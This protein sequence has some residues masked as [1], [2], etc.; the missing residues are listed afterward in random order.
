VVEKGSRKIICVHV[1]KGKKHDFRLFKESKLPI[2]SS[3]QIQ[4]DS[5]Y[6]GIQKK[7][8]N[9]KIPHKGKKKAPLTKAQK[10]ENRQLSSSRVVVENII[11][12]LK[13]FK[14]LAE[15]YRNRR[16]KFGLRL[17]LIAAICNAQLC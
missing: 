10:K 15:K 9:C 6:Q 14:I 5:G 4:A 16:R 11:R 17:N 12:T 2:R 13:I 8:A 1:D 3:T 7:H